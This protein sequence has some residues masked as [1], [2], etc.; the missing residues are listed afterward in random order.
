MKRVVLERKS[1]VNGDNTV[2]FHL[3]KYVFGKNSW[4]THVR[5]TKKNKDGR[6]AIRLLSQNLECDNFMEKLKSQNKAA[7]LRLC[8]DGE[9]QS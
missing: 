6:L 9:T 1:E 3:L 4:W 2:L 5:S 7:I 8:Y